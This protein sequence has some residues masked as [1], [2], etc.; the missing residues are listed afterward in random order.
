[1]RA[2]ILTKA[3]ILTKAHRATVSLSSASEMFLIIT[4]QISSISMHLKCTILTKLTRREYCYINT[5]SLQYVMLLTSG[6]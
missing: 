1:M 2:T 6:G 4:T 5:S 3:I